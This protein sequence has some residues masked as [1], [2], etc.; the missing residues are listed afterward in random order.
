MRT[1]VA[2]SGG[3]DSLFALLALREAGHDVLAL[4]AHFLAPDAVDADVQDRLRHC[5]KTLGVDL[6]IVDLHHKFAELVITPFIEH[7]AQGMTPNPCA[8]C[9]PRIKFGILRDAA[10][11]LGCKGFATGHYVRLL[12]TPNGPLLCR[13]NDP[14][15]EQSY[16]LSLVPQASLDNVVFPLGTRHKST[17]QGEL[18]QRGFT[19]PESE[20]SQ[21]VCFIPGDDYR[22]FLQNTGAPLSGPGPIV[23]RAG[24]QLG[25]HSGLW[26]YTLGQRRGLGI[27][28]SEP[29]YVIDKEIRSNRLVVG[30]RAERQATGCSVHE[31]NTVLPFEKWPDQI[32]VQTNYRQQPVPCRIRVVSETGMEI[33]FLEPKGPAAPGQVAAF[34]TAK[35]YVLG[36]GIIHDSTRT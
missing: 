35:G 3:A 31:L 4:H 29:L 1:A 16:F 17:I 26:R 30:T 11:Q 9:N 15:K 28:Y 20:E 24:N 32:W 36:G 27:A 7:Y 25:H 34:Y 8:L 13:G 22:S 2:V 6:E 21:E 5:C 18:E 19:I 10:R 23:D 33:S 12:Q 14:R